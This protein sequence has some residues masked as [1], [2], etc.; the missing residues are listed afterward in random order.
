MIELTCIVC[1]KGCR[2]RVDENDGYK[3]LGNTCPR[4]EVYG[5]EEALDPKRTVTSTVRILFMKKPASAESDETDVTSL[6]G[7]PDEPTEPHEPTES[8][9]L[10]CKPLP[11]PLPLVS[12]FHPELP[13]IEARLPVKTSAPIPKAKIMEVMAEIN[14]ITVRGPIRIGDI[15]S[16]NIAGT[17]ADLL[18]TRTMCVPDA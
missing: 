1:P 16:G 7:K 14:R 2:L 13:H 12:Y 9:G 6:P 10:V 17:G 4:G 15:I 5:R 3:V 18:A 11:Q 8:D